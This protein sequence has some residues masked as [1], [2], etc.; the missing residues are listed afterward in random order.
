NAE[1]RKFKILRICF[2]SGSKQI[3][4]LLK[5]FGFKLDGIEYGFDIRSFYPKI[6]NENLLKG[7]FRVRHMD[8][9][10]DI[11]AIEMLESQIHRSD[12]SSRVKFETMAAKA[13]LRKYY[14]G[15]CDELNAFVLE[16]CDHERLEYAGVCGFMRDYQRPH[17]AH[18]SSIGLDLKYQRQRMMF[19]FL[20]EAHSM[21]QFAN[22]FRLSGV[23]TTDKLVQLADSRGAEV[24]G[25]SWSK[26][27]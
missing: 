18:I 22:C 16:Y 21:S 15:R 13:S 25:Y 19:P 26:E 7:P 4:V 1:E 9:N 27:V 5:D 23:T 10:S 2:D 8:Y 12:P 17:Y 14:L 20:I 6:L 24:F 11:D 3:G